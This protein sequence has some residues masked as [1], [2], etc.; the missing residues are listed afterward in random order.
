M[1]MSLAV[2]SLS[3]QCIAIP[4]HTWVLQVNSMYT[5]SGKA[6]GAAVMALARQGIFLIPMVVILSL[7]FKET[8]LACTQAVCDLLSMTIAVPYAIKFLKELNVREKEQNLQ[9]LSEGG[10]GNE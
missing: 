1:L 6:A 3:T 7:L 5:A 2:L 10:A 8:G 9:R 4:F